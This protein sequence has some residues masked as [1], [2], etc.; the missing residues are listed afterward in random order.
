[1]VVE[2]KAIID[3][4]TENENE[5]DMEKEIDLTAVEEYVDEDDGDVVDDNP[6]DV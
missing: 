5:L 1:M 6:E 3:E 2:E 4:L